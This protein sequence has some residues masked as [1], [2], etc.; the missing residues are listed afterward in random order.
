MEPSDWSLSF[1]NL[2]VCLIPNPVNR[3]KSK[4]DEQSFSE[5]FKVPYKSSH[6]EF[7]IDQRSMFLFTHF[8]Q[9]QGIKV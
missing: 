7:S 8:F 4:E 2:R 3:V 5:A 1:Q 9:I 6:E